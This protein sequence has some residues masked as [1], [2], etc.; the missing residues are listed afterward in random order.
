MSLHNSRK[1]WASLGSSSSSPAWG[2]RQG[3]DGRQPE[4]ERGKLGPREGIPY[5]TANR[6]PV[7]N[8][9]LLRFWTVDTRREGHSQRSAPQKRHK[10]HRTGHA[11]KLRLGWGGDKSH[12]TWGECAPQAPGCLSCLDRGRHKT[13]AQ[14]SLC[15]CGVPKNLNVS[16]LG[17][18]SARNSG[19]A[20][21]RATWSLS[22]VDR[23]STHAV[24]GGK[25]SVAGTLWILPTHASDVCLQCPSLLTAWLNKRT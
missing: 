23:E 17:L 7:S 25:T 8:Q 19:P 21:C 20:P 24:S 22:S 4:P 18:G 5:Q 11:W 2:R 10:V 9:R 13:Q 12:C 6:F 14:P 1:L 15:L 16:G 3:A